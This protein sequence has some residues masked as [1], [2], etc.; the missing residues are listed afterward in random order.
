MAP[1][2]VEALERAAQQ[3][4][5]KALARQAQAQVSEQE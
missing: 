5:A 3:A 2:T 1:E 4:L